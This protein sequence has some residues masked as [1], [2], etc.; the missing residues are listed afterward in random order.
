VTLLL[1]NAV[2]AFPGVAA[3]QLRPAAA[4]RTE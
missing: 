4:L 2:A 3:A 1:A